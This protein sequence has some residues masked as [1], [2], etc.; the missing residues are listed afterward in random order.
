MK[1]ELVSIALD[2]ERLTRLLEASPARLAPAKLEIGRSGFE[3][4][5]RLLR[6][7]SRL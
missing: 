3:S 5:L 7:T 4:L 2:D 1:T 6:R